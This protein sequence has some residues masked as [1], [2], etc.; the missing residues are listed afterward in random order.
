[1][2]EVAIGQVE[3][4][5][6]GGVFGAESFLLPVVETIGMRDGHMKE[7]KGDGW[8]GE[9]GI[10]GGDEAAVIALVLA[11]VAGLVGR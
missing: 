2:R 1:V 3:V 8:V 6:V 4:V 10:T 11:D 7:E 9:K 5:D